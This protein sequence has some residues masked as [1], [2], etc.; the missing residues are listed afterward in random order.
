[1]P[2]TNPWSFWLEDFPQAQFQASIPQG[3]TPFM[4]YWRS[5]YGNVWGQY[6]GALGKQATA[7][8]PPSL[9]F[10]DYLSQQTPYMEQWQALPERD[11]GIYRGRFAPSLSWRL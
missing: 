7:G 6:Q 9:S 11:R 1:M 2:N 3:T 4:D 5:Q 8:Q 10:G